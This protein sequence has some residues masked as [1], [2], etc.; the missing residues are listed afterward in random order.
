M[1]SKK[2]KNH[3]LA[4]LS[5]TIALMV[6]AY[7]FNRYVLNRST[8]IVNVAYPDVTL[9]LDGQQ[10]SPK[11]LDQDSYQFT[12]IPG[13]H[14]LTIKSGDDI[15]HR[16]LIT[17]RPGFTLELT[18]A[19][20]IAPNP[21]S[22]QV[23]P[24]EFSS[25]SSDL[26]R[27]YYLGQN[28]STLIQYDIPTRLR[29]FISDPVFRNI[30]Q[31]RWA[32]DHQDVIV[33]DNSNNWYFFDF[34]KPNF[35]NSEF[36]LIAGPSVLDVDYDPTHDR[37]GLIEYRDNTPVFA[38]ADAGLDQK[39]VLVVLEKMRSPKLFWSPNG[40]TVALIDQKDAQNN[41]LYFYYLGENRLVDS[42][43]ANINRVTFSP[44]SNWALAESNSSQPQTTLYNLG[45]GNSKQLVKLAEIGAAVWH[46][47]SEYLTTLA[48]VNNDPTLVKIN[49]N[50]SEPVPY[51]NSLELTDPIE[52]IFLSDNEDTLYF[53]SDH[54][55][56]SF[57]LIN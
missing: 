45:D 23:G 53:M 41:Q 52:T 1:I 15:N 25:Q 13:R 8:I 47:D 21:E 11:Q 31:L 28:S 27:L 30:R 18:P 19:L 40:R 26:T 29:S 33:Q 37:V 6:L 5:A 7:T 20:S 56:Y 35:V 9:S 4:I 43:L 50:N 3:Q 54:Q 32:P 2:Y 34:T 16:Q 12:T 48:L 57:P 24:V 14:T 55:L 38:V 51:K 17:A 42:G 36:R 10:L 46:K 44:N 49:V 22:D 39:T